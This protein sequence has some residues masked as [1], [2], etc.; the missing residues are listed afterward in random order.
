MTE[1]DWQTSRHGQHML[2]FFQTAKMPVRTRWLVLHVV[3][4]VSQDDEFTQFD[5]S[6]LWMAV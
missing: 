2:V 6:R 1:D 4:D 5:I 3:V